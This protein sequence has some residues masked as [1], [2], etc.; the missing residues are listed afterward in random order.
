MTIRV[1]YR[2]GAKRT[3][4]KYKKKAYK[5]RKKPSVR[6]GYLPVQQKFIDTFTIPTAIPNGYV[7]RYDFTISQLQNLPSLVRLFDQYRIRKV[8]LQFNGQTFNDP[9]ANPSM[10]CVSSIDLDGGALPA[11]F[12]V[13]LQASNAKVSQWGGT[14]T[15]NLKKFVSVRPRFSNQIVKEL[16]PPILYSQTLGNRNAWI[17]L[18]DQG[19]T[20]HHGVVMGWRA[21]AGALNFAQD[22]TLITT[23][24][25][26]FRKFR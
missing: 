10:T 24:H 5:K 9:T 12:D 13:I 15:N 11:N 21:P 4:T 2:K 1:T 25:L 3:V 19:L 22:V 14:G 8:T 7:T 6:T 17:D 16:G 26:E 23:F 18:A 20:E